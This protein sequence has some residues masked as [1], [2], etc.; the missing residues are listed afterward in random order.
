MKFLIRHTTTYTFSA[1]VFLEPHYLRFKPRNTPHLT[2]KK[3]SLE[4]SP[5]AV[6]ISEQVDPENNTVHFCWFEG[7]HEQMVVNMEMELDSEAYNPFSF[8]VYPLAYFE[9]PFQYDDSLQKLLHSTIKA[10][11]IGIPLQKFGEQVLEQSDGKTVNFLTDLTREIHQTCE[12]IVRETGRAYEP[13]QT[14]GLKKGSCR[15]LAWMQVQLLRNMG[16]AARFVS[17][18]YYIMMDEPAYELHA[19]LEVYIPGGGWIGFDP[20]HGMVASQAHIPV[21]SSAHFENTM[22][23]SGTVRGSSESSM[24]TDLWIEAF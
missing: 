23:I 19:W 21:A 15:D 16:F 10:D 3:F 6:G 7:Q 20:S 5:E 11:P 4:V 14:F 12:V 13:D 18:Y 17:G 1:P 22:A 9:L 24:N 2:V 8:I